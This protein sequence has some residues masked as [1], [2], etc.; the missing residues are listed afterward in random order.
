MLTA[1]NPSIAR[2]KICLVIHATLPLGWCSTLNNQIYMAMQQVQN[3]TGVFRI[4]TQQ[5][6][7]LIEMRTE[8]ESVQFHS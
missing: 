2:T 7:N 1:V 5:E 4:W 8:S 3:D 6:L